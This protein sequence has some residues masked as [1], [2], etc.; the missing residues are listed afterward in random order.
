MDD[1]T[2]EQAMDKLEATLKRLESDK[3][4]LEEAVEA[5]QDATR[6]LR[7][8]TQRLDEARKKIEVRPDAVE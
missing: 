5:A 2:Y 4:S 6:Y 3:L 8:S 7:I 1:L